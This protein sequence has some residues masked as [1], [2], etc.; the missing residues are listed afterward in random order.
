[1]KNNK[2]WE[3]E[4]AEVQTE[5]KK[6]TAGVVISGDACDVSEENVATDYNEEE[7]RNCDECAVAI[8]LRRKEKIAI[9]T[10]GIILVALLVWF[11]FWLTRLQLGGGSAQTM[12]DSAF[13]YTETDGT[14]DLSDE[15]TVPDNSGTQW[16]VPTQPGTIPNT[17]TSGNNGN[18]NPTKDQTGNNGTTAPNNGDNKSTGNDNSTTP[19]TDTTGENNGNGTQAPDTTGGNGDQSGSQPDDTTSGGTTTQPGNNGE[20]GNN[21][22]QNKDDNGN[23]AAS[24]YT[25]DTKIRISQVNDDTGIVTLTIDGSSI[26]VPLQTT[27]FNGRVTKSG[28]AQGKLFGYNAGVTVMFFYPQA[29]G[30]HTTEVNAFMSRTSDGLTILVDINGEGSKLLI[31]VNG[32]KSLF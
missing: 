12:N 5:E 26:A 32:M 3:N 17:G 4:N 21:G 24:D 1:M 18:T 8:G 29:E 16:T 19:P 6:T 2:T 28:V 30:F 10:I 25:G 27:Y 31:K 20:N 22:D 7:C 15:K 11:I 9:M 23:G 14:T 13:S